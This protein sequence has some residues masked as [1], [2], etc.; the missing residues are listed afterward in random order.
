M[1]RAGKAVAGTLLPLEGLLPRIRR[2]VLELLPGRSV[3][4]CWTETG[5]GG[6]DDSSQPPWSSQTGEVVLQ[7]RCRLV[8]DVRCPIALLRQLAVPIAGAVA[9]LAAACTA[10]T[11]AALPCLECLAAGTTQALPA[12]Q[13]PDVLLRRCQLHLPWRSSQ[14]QDS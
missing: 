12:L 2:C 13:H 10:P 7:I 8:G 14:P 6:G 1:N 11:L 5:G 9:P 3:A 4:G